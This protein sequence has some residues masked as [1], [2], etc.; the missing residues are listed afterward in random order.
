MTASKS[1]DFLESSCF[2]ENDDYKEVFFAHK[3]KICAK[4]SEDEET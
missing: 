2:G 3:D 1:K 4:K